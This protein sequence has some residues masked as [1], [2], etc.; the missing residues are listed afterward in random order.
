MRTLFL[1]FALLLALVVD[2]RAA[3]YTYSTTVDLSSATIQSP[4]PTSFFNFNF[5]TNVQGLDLA[6]GDT[7]SGTITFDQALT[8]TAVNPQGQNFNGT[9]SFAPHPSSPSNNTDSYTV[10]LDGL[11]GT[12]GSPNPTSGTGSGGGLVMG[13]GGIIT[14]PT[15]SFTGITY[16]FTVDSEVQG[17]LTYIPANLSVTSNFSNISLTAA[18]EPS[19]MALCVMGFAGLAL[20]AARLR[21]R[22]PL[23]NR[24]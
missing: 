3:D 16:S 11:Q 21:H 8:I 10:T 12:E 15:L 13:F 7:V 23:V 19:T 24:A 6:V 4:G 22:E 20:G 18:P 17:N 9:F 14:S 1:A 2:L 5:P